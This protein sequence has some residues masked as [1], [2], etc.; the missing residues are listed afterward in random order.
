M[1]CELLKF[2][3]F[4]RFDGFSAEKSWKQSAGHFATRISTALSPRSKRCDPRLDNDKVTTPAVEI[5]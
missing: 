3:K 2:S 1:D 5:T 4:L